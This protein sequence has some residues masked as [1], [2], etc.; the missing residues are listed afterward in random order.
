MVDVSNFTS[1]GYQENLAGIFSAEVSFSG[2]YDGSEAIAAGDSLAI[3]FATGG[4]GP[5]LAPTVRLSSI[6]IDTAAKGKAATI[7]AS[8]TSNG[9]YSIT[10]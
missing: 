1:G 8:G 2:P 5:S 10:I 7:S 3:T 4:G 6:K 9:S